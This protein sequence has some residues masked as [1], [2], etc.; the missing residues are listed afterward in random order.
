MSG[1]VLTRQIFIHLSGDTMLQQQLSTFKEALED[2]EMPFSY[3][4]VMIPQARGDQETTPTP[5]RQVKSI[6]S[7]ILTM[8]VLK[9]RKNLK[10]HMGLLRLPFGEPLGALIQ[11]IFPNS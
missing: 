9:I 8:H 7:H 6:K 10:G 5:K 4:P 11:I 3:F 1:T 2:S